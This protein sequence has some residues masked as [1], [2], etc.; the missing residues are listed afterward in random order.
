M[1]NVQSQ[2]FQPNTLASAYMKS[3]VFIGTT[4]SKRTDYTNHDDVKG[5]LKILENLWISVNGSLKILKSI[6][7]YSILFEQTTGVAI[8]TKQ[9]SS[10]QAYI[11]SQVE[12]NEKGS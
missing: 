2:L 11:N 7:W 6:L 12:C 4:E 1:L 8:Q 5:C 9:K 10:T 3:V